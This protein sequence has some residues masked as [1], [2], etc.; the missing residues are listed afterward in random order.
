MPERQQQMLKYGQ[1]RVR[2]YQMQVAALAAS[3]YGAW[4][5]LDIT[6]VQRVYGISFIFIVDLNHTAERCLPVTVSAAL[7]WFEFLSIMM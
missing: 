4:N 7:F 5:H 1:R 6:E 2:N 3:L